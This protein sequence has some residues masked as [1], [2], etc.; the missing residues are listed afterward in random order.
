[1]NRLRRHPIL[2][3]LGVVLAILLALLGI[4]AFD[5]E[6]AP[7][8]RTFFTRPPVAFS[9]GSGWA[10][11]AGFHAPAG[12]EPRAFGA[13]LHRASLQRKPGTASRAAVRPLEVRAADELLCIPQ[14]MDC[15]RAFAQRPETIAD[16]G[17]DNAVLLAR[18]EEL[19]GSRGLADV[20]EVFDYYEAILPHFSTVLRVQQVGLSLAGV[21]AAAGRAGKAVA[22]LEADAAFHR[23]WLE[24]AGSILTKMLAVRTLSRDFL[25][26]GH[27]ARS[28]R[29][30]EPAQWEAL[31]R[32]AAPLTQAERGAAPVLRIEATLFAILLDRM[33]ADS[34]TTSRIIEASR[35]GSSITSALLQP[36]ATLNFAH[37]VFAAWTTLDPVPSHE[38]ARAIERVEEQERVHLAIR[39]SWLYNFAG[40]GLVR[41]QKPQLA[42]YLYRVRDLDALA[43]TIRCTIELRRHGVA[44]E[45]AAAHVAAS[46]ACIDPYEGKPLGWDDGR[47]ELSYRARSPKQVSRFGG[48]GDRVTFAVF[49]AR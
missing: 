11:L 40:K 18:Y 15:V 3:A 28:G 17:A 20:F 48:R 49:P 25:V 43:A 35:L 47:G 6:L 8:A 30:L 1:M 14:D 38:L 21:D 39:W 12:E 19:L 9:Q 44:R 26:A 34:R 31:A 22:W 32:I 27:V 10:L 23:L 2:A 33:I 46:P 42:E 29:E 45:A 5:Q 16:L 41:E 4:N 7:E 37:P 13:A 36:N 24:E